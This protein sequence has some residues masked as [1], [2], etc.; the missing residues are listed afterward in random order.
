MIQMDIRELYPPLRR[1]YDQQHRINAT[2]FTCSK[3]L[4]IGW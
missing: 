2:S 1:K 4:N 3:S